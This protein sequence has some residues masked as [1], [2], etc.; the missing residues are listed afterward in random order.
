LGFGGQHDFVSGAIHSPGGHAIIA[1]RSWHE[2][3]D[4]SNVVPILRQPVCSF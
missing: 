2:K 3:S 4:V 1:L